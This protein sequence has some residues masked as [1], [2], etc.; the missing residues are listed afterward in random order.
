MTGS[1]RTLALSSGC[2]AAMGWGLTGTFI[3]LMPEFTTLEILSV[4]LVIAF[5]VT[6][7]ILILHH[8][9]RSELRMLISKPM[10]ILLSSLMV[11]YYLFAVRAF[12]LA[13][14]SDVV[15]VVGLSPLLGLAVKVGLRKP[16]IAT[17]GIGAITAFTGLVLF[18]LPKLQGSQSNLSI[19]LTGLFFAFLSAIVT[20]AYASFFKAYSA[21]Q[22]R[23]NPLLVAFI[24]FSIG[25]IF[26]APITF[27]SAPQ[28]FNSLLQ[29]DKLAVALGLGVLS[30]VVPTL[31][32]S[33]AAKH[34][35]P[36]L[37]TALNLMTPIFAAA[38]AALLLNEY[39]SL[40][41]VAGAALIV[42]GILTLSMPQR[43]VPSARTVKPK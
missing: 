10:T 19:Y 7:P 16:L 41:S 42:I 36:V 5:L 3:K 29:P 33:Y 2:C 31:C 13:P 34:L 32:Y 21:T 37:T 39:L 17:E 43:H 22:S 11:F 20:L 6:S 1:T 38:I 4:R 25:S 35:S 12:Q 14:V 26:I 15:L 24:T 28:Y 30:T 18:V 27:V 9:L 40:W 23:L 8:S